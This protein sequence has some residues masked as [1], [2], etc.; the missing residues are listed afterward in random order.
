MLGFIEVLILAALLLIPLLWLAGRIEIHLPG[1]ELRASWG[2]R[3]F[4]ALIFLLAVWG[5]L[6]RFAAPRRSLLLALTTQKLL[7]AGA[8]AFICLLLIE[9]TMA[10]LGIGKP[11]P[12][13][14]VRGAEYREEAEDSPFVADRDLLF[15]FRPGGTINR[16]TINSLGFPER[17]VDPVKRPG[18]VRVICLGD[19]C[20]ADGIPPYSTILNELLSQ[21]PPDNRD[22]E[23]FHNAVHGYTVVQGQRLFGKT[24]RDL[25]PDVVTIYYGW[26]D[27]WTADTPDSVR[28][29]SA[30]NLLHHQFLQGLSEKRFYQWA[31]G[32]HGASGDEGPPQGLRVDPGEYRR[33]LTQ[34]VEDIRE[35]G[36]TPMLLTA[37][38]AET[39]HSIVAERSGITPEEVLERH[40]LYV[41]LTRVVAR[42]TGATLIDL[43]A[44]FEGDPD[45]SSYFMADGIHFTLEGRRQVARRIYDELTRLE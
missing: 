37:P 11:M 42:D 5:G 44:E 24:T 36:T 23:S 35:T 22:W 38:R 27:H 45:R 28:I 3:P 17:D 6:R 32:L 26:N 21:S 15:R 13:I 34:L 2:I 12:P 4:V 41:D 1:I 33:T 25:D 7:L 18:A 19:S 39:L 29:A 8:S 10:L 30:R 40:D 43:A 20:T 31:V 14:L 9:G 16:Q